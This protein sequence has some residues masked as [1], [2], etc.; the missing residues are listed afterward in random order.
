MIFVSAVRESPGNRRVAE[1]VS[2]APNILSRRA[3]SAADSPMEIHCRKRFLASSLIS[4]NCKPPPLPVRFAHNISPVA[5]INLL[6]RPG[7]KKRKRS[8]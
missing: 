4:T 6:L 2:A 3:V 5:S 7:S 1:A 8:D